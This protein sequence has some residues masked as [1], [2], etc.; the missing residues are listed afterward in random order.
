VIVVIWVLGILG[1]VLGVALAIAFIV[2]FLGIFHQKKR[3][4]KKIDGKL[5]IKEG[6]GDWEPWEERVGREHSKK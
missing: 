1:I 3:E 2:I 6:K 4:Y 5:Y